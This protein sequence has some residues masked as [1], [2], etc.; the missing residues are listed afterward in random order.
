VEGIEACDVE[1]RGALPERRLCFGDDQG[2]LEA[3]DVGA[4]GDAVEGGE[5]V[6]YLVLDGS[7]LLDERLTLEHEFGDGHVGS[8]F[9]SLFDCGMVE[10]LRRRGLDA[11]RT[12]LP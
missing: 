11:R 12:G 2:P 6:S 4:F 5:G 8:S 10:L 9:V 1:A 7:G 3:L